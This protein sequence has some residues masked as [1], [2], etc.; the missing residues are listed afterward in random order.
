MKFVFLGPK[1]KKV[2]MDELKELHENEL[3]IQ[4]RLPH[5]NQIY[6]I[7]NHSRQVSVQMTYF[8]YKIIHDRL[9]SSSISVIH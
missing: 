6:I 4:M 1:K 9:K 3:G 7:K 2:A 8:C 5:F